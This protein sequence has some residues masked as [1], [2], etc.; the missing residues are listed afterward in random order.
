MQVIPIASAESQ[1]FTPLL[2]NVRAEFLI[3]YNA[4]CDRWYLEL[5]VD[6]ICVGPFKMIDRSLLI[7]GCGPAEFGDLIIIPRD[8]AVIDLGIDGFSS[9]AMA[10][11]YVTP[12]EADILRANGY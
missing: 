5:S 6:D 4:I 12:A 8:P 3:S 10:L 11:I 9:G 7:G 1:T 2:D